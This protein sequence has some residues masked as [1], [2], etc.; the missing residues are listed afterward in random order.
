MRKLR[1]NFPNK[2]IDEYREE[3]QEEEKEALL[4]W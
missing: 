4:E 3:R 2:F 1:G